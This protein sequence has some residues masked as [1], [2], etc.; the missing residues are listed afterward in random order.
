MDFQR[1]PEHEDTAFL[2]LA[3]AV[4]GPEFVEDMKLFA[5]VTPYPSS[6]YLIIV[7]LLGYVPG[8]HKW[9]QI[10]DEV[11]FYCRIHRGMEQ[12]V[13]NQL[14]LTIEKRNWN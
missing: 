1:I 12:L 7:E 11:L 14:Q 10:G 5:E 2:E 9:S 8:V 13:L 6:I 4:Y 3:E